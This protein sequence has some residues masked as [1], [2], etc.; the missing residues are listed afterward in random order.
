LTGIL[1]FPKIK[2]QVEVQRNKI[3]LYCNQVFITDSVENIVPEFLT[4]L[5]GVI[6]SPDIPLNVSRS[7]LQADSNVKKISAHITK[8]VA[9]KLNEMF[10]KDRKDFETKWEDL[11]VFVE[12][13]ILSEDKFAERAN[14]FSLLK[15]TDGECFT[16]EEYK[17]KVKAL[18][19]NKNEKIVV[20]YTHDKDS[21]FSFVKKAKERGY[22]VLVMNSPLTPHYISKLEQS[23]ND[24]MF[25]RIDSD[26]IDKLIQ[27][28]EEIP[29]KLSKEQEDALKPV[30]E[31][32]V[33]DSKFKVEFQ[34][35]SEKDAPIMI[36]QPEFIRRMMEQQK[37]G[38]GGFF[39]AFPESYNMVVNSNHNKIAELISIEDES[40]KASR[41]KQLSDLALLSQGML[42]GEALDSFIERSIELV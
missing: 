28:D 2:E 5:H 21:Q 6:D 8:K 7:Y 3:Q 23:N 12:Y 20:L 41:V 33:N 22:D 40:T 14:K 24:M 39:G 11:K 9:D 30:F 25:A 18:Q 37:F 36:T 16:I 19:T 10:N 26:S 15:N 35:L 31:T 38:G 42:K 34:S 4:L 1:F 29:S 17:E 32:V 27:K 13:G